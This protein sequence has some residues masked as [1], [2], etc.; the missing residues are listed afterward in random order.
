MK[1]SVELVRRMAGTFPASF[2]FHTNKNMLPIMK[3]ATCF[4]LYL[5][6]L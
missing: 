2:A 4:Y 3:K 1:A 5:N 6:H